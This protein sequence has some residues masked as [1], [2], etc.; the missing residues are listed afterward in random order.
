MKKASRIFSLLLGATVLLTSFSGCGGKKAGG[1]DGTQ[2]VQGTQ[3]TEEATLPIVKTPLKITWWGTLA[4]KFSATMKSLGEVEAIKHIQ[5]KTGITIEFMHPGTD[6]T[7]Q[8]N[9]I[10]A[11]GDIP[12]VIYNGWPSVSGGP[13]KYMDDKVII[14]LNDLIDKYSPNYKKFL[15][16]YPE[17]HKQLSLDDKSIYMYGTCSVEPITMSTAG[18][19][20][21]KDWLDKLGLNVPVT[22]EDWYNV[23]TAFK[24][25]DPSGVGT[26]PFLASKN[27]N[28]KKLAPAWGIMVDF[29]ND[30]GTIKY[31]PKEQAYKA[32]LTEMARWYK[33]GLIDP[34]YPVVSSSVLDTKVTS[35]GGTFY[36]ALSGGIGKYMNLMADKNPQYNLVGVPSP[37][38]PGGKSYTPNIQRISNTQTGAAISAN[39]K[40]PVETAKLLDYFFSEEMLEMGNWGIKGK[41]YEVVN[42]K[43]QYTNEIL[44]NPNGLT[45]DQ[46]IARY[47]YPHEQAAPGIQFHESREQIA[48]TLPQQKQAAETWSKEDTSLMILPL[49]ITP[50]KMERYTDIMKEVNAYVNEMFDKFVVG[51]EPMDRF[52]DYVKQ[53]NRLGVD[54]AVQFM[55]EAYNRSKNR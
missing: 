34:E 10:I 48:F 40:H 25:K 19:L 14:P 33:E 15:A 51:K 8:L 5:E 2:K 18:F 23:L 24:V 53:L 12:D 6:G 13:G 31:G 38:G 45:M 9:L 30:K 1:E 29:Y 11:S 47:A 39:N 28:I 52:D 37:V 49:W 21:R 4:T 36:A 16:Q 54:E 35:N 41:S 3:K 27:G 22:V 43:K 42:G 20:M 44:K 46:A 26:V 17:V 7:Q 50:D 32:Y 55:Q